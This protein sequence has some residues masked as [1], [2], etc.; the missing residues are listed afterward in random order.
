ME[1]VKRD[2]LYVVVEAEEKELFHSIIDIERRITDINSSI[3]GLIDHKNY[4]EYE[5]QVKKRKQDDCR[6]KKEQSSK[7]IVQSWVDMAQRY[8]IPLLE[9]SLVSILPSEILLHIFS[10][11]SPTDVCVGASRV[12]QKWH[13]IAYDNLLWRNIC[14]Q[15]GIEV[16]A[17]VDLKKD[18]RTNYM[19]GYRRV[20]NWS[21]GKYKATPLAGHKE[22]V[23]SVL[24]DGDRIVSG[25]EDMSIK[26]WE[27]ESGMCLNTLKGHKNGVICLSNWGDRVVSGSADGTIRVWDQESGQCMRTINTYSSVWS[28]QIL[29]DKVFCGCVDTSL[30]VF[31]LNTGQ[32][33]NTFRGHTAP[34]RSLQVV[35][36]YGEP[37]IIS[38]SYDRTIRMWDLNGRTLNTIRA[39][40]HKVNCLQFHDNVLVSGSH[41]TL[42]KV[43]DMSG[44]CM[45]TLQGHDNM[46]HCLQFNGNKLITGSSD[47]TMK[48][49]N[50]NTGEQINTM[51]SQSAVCALQFDSSRL[52]CGHEDSVIQIYD[53]S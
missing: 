10:F 43:W 18:A 48:L 20:Q 47:T 17:Q 3:K 51:K 6:R 24:F 30:R 12:N 32:A 15:K 36:A 31:D 4:L 39:H 8:H 2:P 19:Q 33:L 13:T 22:I 52:I 50:I 5:L 49:W 14:I 27:A 37:V 45:H 42:V 23:W 53:F 7:L 41:D 28:L 46:I 21:R 38:G 11:M 26:I 34:V 40:T 25:S 35:E 29:G 16:P 44:R 1:L 9:L